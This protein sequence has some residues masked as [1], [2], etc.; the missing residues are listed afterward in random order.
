MMTT[1][2]PG[3]TYTLQVSGE[4]TYVGFT[5]SLHVFV[6]ADGQLVMIDESDLPGDLKL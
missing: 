2:T 5:V 3:N 1:M 4:C 6:T